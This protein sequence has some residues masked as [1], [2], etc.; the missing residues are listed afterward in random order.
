M[1]TVIT[2]K[3]AD[4]LP[5]HYQLKDRDRSLDV[6]TSNE[7]KTQQGA[8]LVEYDFL[9]NANDIN[10]KNYTTNILT[11]TKTESELFDLNFTKPDTSAVV[12]NIQFANNPRKYLTIRKT[13]NSLSATADLT[14]LSSL[15][16]DPSTSQS[17]VFELSTQQGSSVAK[18]WTWD[19]THKKYL[20][21]R[22]TIDSIHIG[23]NANQPLVFD[24]VTSSNID[25]AVFNV[26]YDKNESKEKLNNNIIK[27]TSLLI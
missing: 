19:G 22:N 10:I 2:K 17:F 24:T 26:V 7:I 18:I 1:A 9:T 12:T 16:E 14:P 8:S 5:I 3:Y 15:V 13:G 4:I 27:H 23:G 11:D 20:V 21:Q 6:T 25:R